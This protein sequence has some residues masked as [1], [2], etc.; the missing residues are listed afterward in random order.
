MILG[1]SG[2]SGFTLTE[3]LIGIVLSGIVIAGV[4]GFFVS[5]IKTYSL[6]EQ[7][8]EMQENAR[9]ALDTIVMGLQNAGYDPTSSDKFGITTAAFS[10][11]NDPVLSLTTSTELYFTVDESDAPRT[12]TNGDGVIDNNPDERFGFRINSNTLEAQC[13]PD[14]NPCTDPWEAVADNIESMSVTYTYEDPLQPGQWLSSQVVGLP[15]NSTSDRKFELIKA[16]TIS[17]TAKTSQAD[18]N[19][20]V[21]DGHRRL[22][23]S[24]EVAPRNL[25]Y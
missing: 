2:E 14:P 16:V 9:I 12:A 23:L 10:D 19:Y 15:S 6:Q 25:A 17:L 3:L 1:N 18:P 21:G 7:L 4:Y 8:V 13:F 11:S 5:Q 20:Q 22:T 24:A